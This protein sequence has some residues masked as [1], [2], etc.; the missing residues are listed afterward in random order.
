MTL[1]LAVTQ[2]E[3]FYGAAWY[4]APA[5][6]QTVDGYAPW[7]VVWIAWRAMN[8]MVAYE[9]LSMSRAIAIALA[10]GDAAGRARQQELD[11]A[12]PAD[13]EE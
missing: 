5:R 4:H 3:R 1:A 11:L 9:R 12:F 2:V 13:D 8:A 10:Q 6:W 7:Q